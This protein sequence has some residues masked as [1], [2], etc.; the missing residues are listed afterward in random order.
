MCIS[1]YKVNDEFKASSI[2]GKAAKYCK[3]VPSTT[4]EI[5][6]TSTSTEAP[7]PTTTTAKVV[8]TTTTQAPLPKTTSLPPT[9]KPTHHDNHT[10]KPNVTSPAVDDPVMKKTVDPGAQHI[11]GGIMIPIFVVAA[12]IGTIFAARKYDLIDRTRAF[13]RNRRYNS[14]YNDVIMENDFDDP[15]LI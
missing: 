3:E 4:T 10:K 11:F 2:A 13:L 9:A 14:Q 1:G 8:V 15:P 7:K 5:H 6:T 12:F